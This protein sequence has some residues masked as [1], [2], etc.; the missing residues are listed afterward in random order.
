MTSGLLTSTINKNKLH[1]KKILTPTTLNIE[2]YNNYNSIYN[3]IK[4]QIKIKYYN[5]LFLENRTNMKQTW[6][7]LNKLINKQNNKQNL[8]ETIKLNNELLTH[9]KQI[10]DSF[11]DFFCEH[12]KKIK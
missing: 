8:P 7:E 9:P 10:A 4:R 5:N 6:L 12:R 2:R 3:R 1:I 11:N